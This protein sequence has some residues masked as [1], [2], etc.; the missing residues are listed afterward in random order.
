MVENPFT[1]SGI[2]IPKILMPQISQVLEYSRAFTDLNGK[3]SDLHET[4]VNWECFIL[5][6]MILFSGLCVHSTT[7]QK[8]G[9]EKVI[10]FP[11]LQ[12]MSLIRKTKRRD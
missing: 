11:N 3:S 8:S 2:F 5:I 12:Q 6:L 10:R 4:I 1:N 9:L 7:F